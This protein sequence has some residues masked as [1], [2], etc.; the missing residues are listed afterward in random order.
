MPL[1]DEQPGSQNHKGGQASGRVEAQSKEK[2]GARQNIPRGLL[3]EEEQAE[4]LD[5]QRGNDRYEE[6][7]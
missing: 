2:H 3:S 6:F 1:S 7:T 5:L 4:F